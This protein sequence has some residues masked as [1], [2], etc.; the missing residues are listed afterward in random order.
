VAQEAV[1][2]GAGAVRVE[3][4]G[5]R[6]VKRRLQRQLGPLPGDG[7]AD[8]EEPPALLQQEQAVQSREYNNINV[9]SNSKVPSLPAQ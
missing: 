8:D 1:L 9:P 3:A 7:V 2:A 5:E 4:A 6:G